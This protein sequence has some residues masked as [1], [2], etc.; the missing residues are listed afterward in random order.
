[1]SAITQII[2]LI[3]E[4]ISALVALISLV[5]AAWKAFEARDYRQG[6]ELTQETL[7]LLIA[8]VEM[9]PDGAEKDRLTSTIRTI[10]EH[11]DADSAGDL[12]QNLDN[13]VHEVRDRLRQ[14]GVLT[15]GDDTGEVIRASEALNRWRRMRQ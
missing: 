3:P 11:L 8:S 1:M 13:I 2:D 7:D 4:I 5:V 9:L 12:A 15:T 6:F 10:S 14:T